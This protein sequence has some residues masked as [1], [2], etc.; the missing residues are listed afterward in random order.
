MKPIRGTTILA[1]KRPGQTV[2]AGDGQVS[3]DKIVLKHSARKVRTLHEGK[4]LALGGGG[5]NLENIAV[6]WTV[7]VEELLD[8]TG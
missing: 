4:V 6:G 3:M 1:V 5:Y 7:V 2:M 8:H